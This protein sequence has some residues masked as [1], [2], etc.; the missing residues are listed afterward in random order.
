M[1]YDEAQLVFEKF[2]GELKEMKGKTKPGDTIPAEVFFMFMDVLIP[3]FEGI[4]E[5]IT[6]LKGEGSECK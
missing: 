2:K 5:E 1:K 4:I 3:S 6:K